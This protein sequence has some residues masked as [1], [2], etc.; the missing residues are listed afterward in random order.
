MDGDPGVLV[1]VV[2]SLGSD[3][4]GLVCHRAADEDVAIL[5]DHRGIAEYEVY[6]SIYVTVAVELAEGMG[7]EGILVASNGTAVK[8]CLV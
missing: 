4:V 7:V 5:D 1:G 8:H 6:G 3:H 2:A